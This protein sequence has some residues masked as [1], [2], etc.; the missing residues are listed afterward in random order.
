MCKQWKAE[1]FSLVCY[2]KRKVQRPMQLQSE[3]VT[4]ILHVQEFTKL[5]SKD[6]DVGENRKGEGFH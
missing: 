2:K 4:Q 3:N 6:L 5:V 1:F